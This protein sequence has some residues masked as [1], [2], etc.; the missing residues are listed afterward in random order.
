MKRAEC[1]RRQRVEERL[2]KSVQLMDG[3]RRA[4]E[5]AD[6]SYAERPSRPR[7]GGAGLRPPSARPAA[8]RVQRAQTGGSQKPPFM[9]KRAERME[10]S[11]LDSS[12]ASAFSSEGE[13]SEGRPTLPEE[14]DLVAPDRSTSLR[15]FGELG[16]AEGFAEAAVFSSSPSARRGARASMSSSSA[17]SSHDLAGM[18][19]FDGSWFLIS[20]TDQPGDREVDTWLVTLQITGDEVIDGTGKVNKLVLSDGDILFAGGRLSMRGDRLYRYGRTGACYEYQRQEAAQGGG[21]ADCG[22]VEKTNSLSS[23]WQS[24]DST[25]D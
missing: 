18:F 20:I 24:E 14:L 25:H 17:G 13:C 11:A 22:N 7:E 2:R 19:Q 16:P 15:S 1:G 9:P 21:E 8:P 12:P 4:L 6:A 10:F 3:M 5:L 23:N